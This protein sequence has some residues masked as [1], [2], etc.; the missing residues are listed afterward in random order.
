M[1][2]SPKRRISSMDSAMK[3]HAEERL[4]GMAAT[5]IIRFVRGRNARKNLVNTVLPE[6]MAKGR[7]DIKSCVEELMRCSRVP[8]LMK[9]VAEL[10]TELLHQHFVL[11]DFMHQAPHLWH[12]HNLK[13]LLL[14]SSSISPSSVVILGNALRHQFCILAELSITQG[15]IGVSGCQAIADF[16]SVSRTIRVLKLKN[17]RMNDKGAI[18]IARVLTSQ[19]STEGLQHLDISEN[20]L[21]DT[22]AA[23]LAFAVR[24][25][26]TP[27]V[28]LNLGCNLISKNGG[29]AFAAALQTNR[30][31][32][33]LWLHNNELKPSCCVAL[34]HMLRH[35]SVLLD[36][37][38][39]GNS[40][41]LDFHDSLVAYLKDRSI[42]DQ[43]AIENEPPA[44]WH[45]PASYRRRLNHPAIDVAVDVDT[46]SHQ[47]RGVMDMVK[48]AKEHCS[49][50]MSI[51]RV[52][53]GGT[54][55]FEHALFHVAV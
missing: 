28:G 5:S 26:V 46:S 15:Q 53:G 45:P 49:N 19:Q 50:Q 37:R 42:L 23:H 55:R 48:G 38:L 34:M 32:R 30:S 35:N 6:I 8:C 16:L 40:L 47:E 7:R 41:P 17:M 22:A 20:R 25:K 9:R 3:K 4:E 13:V 27:L 51:F 2:V 29:R 44:W 18:C 39:D 14:S 11:P 52:V 43:S 10:L 33:Q 31:L 12:G 36:L 21:S 1:Q 54:V 24:A